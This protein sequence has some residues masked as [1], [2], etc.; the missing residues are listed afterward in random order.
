MF[1][2]LF[3]AVAPLSGGATG[4]LAPPPVHAQVSLIAE[5]SAAVPGRPAALGLLFR[6]DPDWHIYWRNPGDSGQPPI[7]RWQLPGEVR[8]GELEWPVPERIEV[9]GLVN[10]GYTGEVLLPVAI[11]VPASARPGSTLALGA[12][13]KYLICHDVCMPGKA[14]VELALPVSA[15]AGAPSPEAL[16]FASARARLPVPAPASVTARASL[17]NREFIVSIRTGRRETSGLFFP[18]EESRIDDSAPQVVTPLA[19]GIR[20]RLRASNQLA[21]TP[22]AL[23]AVVVLSGNRLYTIRAPIVGRAP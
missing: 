21:T 16:L 3:L 20:F 18:I 9:S 5:P 4:Q 8:A 6:L 2:V 15:T 13:V 14:T 10:Y 1:T 11:D 19:D 23:T 17:E 12:E 22:D 7:V